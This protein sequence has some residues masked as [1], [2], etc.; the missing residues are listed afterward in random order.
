VVRP[1]DQFFGENGAIEVGGV[2][3]RDH[4]KYG[5]ISSGRSWRQ[6]SNIGA[7]KIGQKLGKSLYYHYISG[8]GFGSLT[9]LTCPE[10]RGPDPATEGV[11]AL[12][13]SCYP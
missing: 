1:T 9:G 4:E 8:F 5:W 3:I 11:S 10:R 2:T 7:I 12:S 13:L 6:S